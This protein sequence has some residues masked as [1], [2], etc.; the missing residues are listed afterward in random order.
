MGKGL[1]RVILGDIARTRC[2]RSGMVYFEK[3]IDEGFG[4]FFKVEDILVDEEGVELTAFA[5]N[6]SGGRLRISFGF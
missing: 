6:Y 1:T 5:K 4:Q 3:R 2:K